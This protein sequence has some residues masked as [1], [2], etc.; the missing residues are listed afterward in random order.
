V[1]FTDAVY[2]IAMTLIV[3]GLDA[4]TLRP[5][6]EDSA[7]ALF[8]GLGDMSSSILMFFVTF[9][10]IGQY[11]IANHRFTGGLRAIDSHL[12]LINLGYLSL[13]AFLPFP[14]S[15]LGDYTGNPVAVAL[16]AVTMAL[17]SALEL[18]QLRHARAAGLL[19]NPPDDDG[20][21]W[22][23]LANLNPVFWFAVSVVIAFG[24]DAEWAML[25]WLLAIP[26]ARLV[27][28]WRPASLS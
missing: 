4:P 20:F 19:A 5:A 22:M 12:I 2:A 8:E 9:V 13:V 17:I 16:F 1:F 23:S 15:L 10:V 14:A 6:D 24:A 18:A 21:R 7:R 26:S 11:W 25:T 28:R 27:E 3:V